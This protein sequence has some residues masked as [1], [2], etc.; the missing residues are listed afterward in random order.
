M[1]LFAAC[2]LAMALLVSPALAQEYAYGNDAIQRIIGAALRDPEYPD[3]CLRRLKECFG[4]FDL[5]G[6]ILA[7]PLDL[8]VRNG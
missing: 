1:R 6:A 5:A 2:L 8:G 7:S 3:R 4:R